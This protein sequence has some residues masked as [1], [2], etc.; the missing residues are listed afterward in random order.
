LDGPILD[1]SGRHYLV[2]KKIVEGLGGRPL[3][4]NT[5][6]ALKRN[7]AG[8]RLILKLSGIKSQKEFKKRWMK[9]IEVRP[10]LRHDR[11][12]PSVKTSL[13][14]L[15]E[16]HK[17][18]LVTLRNSPANLKWQLNRLGLKKYFSVV[19]RKSDNRADW[20]TKYRL[21]KKSGEL[22]LPAW[23]IGD[24]EIDILA[25]RKL[26]MNTIAVTSGIRSRNFLLKTRPD[27]I[28]DS[29]SAAIETIK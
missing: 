1:V 26:K 20:R 12:W 8:P 7:K 9:L 10:Y 5:Y 4:K 16:R 11:V 2:Y 15:G 3:N 29:L 21:I 14:K 25:G 27:H 17:L 6:W 23:I 24:T 18:V 28:T 13:L 22:S 19:L